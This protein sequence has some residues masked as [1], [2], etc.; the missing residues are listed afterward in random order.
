MRRFV[1]LVG[2]PWGVGGFGIEGRDT[3]L[4]EFHRE[5][6]GWAWLAWRPWVAGSVSLL[7]LR[8]GGAPMGSP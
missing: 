2:L 3:G 7:A 6:C 4:A 8:G 1:A 5:W